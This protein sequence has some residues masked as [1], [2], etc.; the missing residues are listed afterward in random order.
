LDSKN[1][2]NLYINIDHIY[3]LYILYIILNNNNLVKNIKLIY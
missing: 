2:N 1:P 3:I